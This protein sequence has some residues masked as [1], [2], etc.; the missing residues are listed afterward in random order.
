[1]RF[2][3]FIPTIFGGVATLLGVAS[4]WFAYFGKYDIATFCAAM[5]L[6]IRFDLFETRQMERDDNT[7][8]VMASSLRMIDTLLQHLNSK[9]DQG[10]SE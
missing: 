7:F 8:R 5:S 9:K 3:R 1:M 2:A 6:L 10:V 4:A